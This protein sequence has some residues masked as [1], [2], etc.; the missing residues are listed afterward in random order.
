MCGIA[1][2]VH[3]NGRNADAAVAVRMSAALAHR[4]PDGEGS[5]E[6]GPVAFAHR[7]LSI[8]DI[9]GGAQPM[10]SSTARTVISYNGE[11]YNSPAL[12]DRL[13]G[14]GCEF[15][16][17]SDTE[18]ILAAYETWGAEAFGELH[19]MYAFALYDRAERAVFLAR[20]PMGIKPLYLCER[21]GTVYF[22]SEV[23]AIRA[24]LDGL[25]LNTAA[26]NAFFLRQY[27]G[28]P[29]TIF[30]EVSSVEPG[31]YRRLCWSGGTERSTRGTFYQMPI[32][33]PR[34]ISLGRAADQLD[35]ELHRAVEEHMLSDVPVGLFLSGGLDSSLLLAFASDVSTEPLST[36]SVGFGDARVDETHHARL[37]AESLGARHHELRVSAGEG[38]AVLPH[39]VAQ[40]D[41]PLA[42][43]AVVPTYVMSRFAAEHVKVVLSGEGADELFGGYRKRYLPQL[44]A[45]PLGT[46]MAPRNIYGPL[47]FM[48]R[49]RRRLL[50]PRYV[51]AASLVSE[52]RLR[53]DLRR[54]RRAGTVNAALRADLRN[55]L[56][57]DL[58]MKVDKMGMLAS[59][60]ARVPYLDRGVV[61]MVS[62]WPASVK[63]DL[64]ATKRVLRELVAKRF[65]DSISKRPKQGFTVPVGQWFR[66]GLREEFEARV[67]SGGACDEWIERPAVEALWQ[68]HQRGRD[69]SLMLWSIFVFAWWLET[70]R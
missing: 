62:A 17:R 13:R 31:T 23:K 59:L 44:L 41:Q 37:V 26:V 55:W 3:L 14:L 36:F 53:D 15:R 70:H 48:E 4:G 22:A 24:V 56:V 67:F 6:E 43:Y 58:L 10:E 7:R 16:T 63:L 29:Q 9:E 1:G 64:R 25:S 52:Q 39:I 8:I 65:P 2:L 57:D 5:L 28:G 12:R 68:Q 11:V 60:E 38:L 47:L 51:P 20:D 54:F 40:M 66:D 30:E 50:G 35:A 32:T 69:R 33:E 27:I 49:A 61:E 45:S 21:N 18:V 46:R 34:P 19:G 42:D